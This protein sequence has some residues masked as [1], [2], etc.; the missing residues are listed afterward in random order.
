MRFFALTIALWIGVA[1]P[2]PV[3]AADEKVVTLAAD[4][5]CPYNCAP[6]SDKPGILVEIAKQAF[7]A[8]GYKLDYRN[9]VWTRAIEEARTGKIT[10]IIGA[11]KGDAPDFIFPET[12]QA[13]SI[14]AFYAP[15]TS[16][17]RYTGLDSLEDISLGVI[18]GYAYGDDIDAYIA[19][20]SDNLQKIQSLDGDEALDMNILKLQKGRIHALVESRNVMQFQLAEKNLDQAIIEVGALPL[21]EAQNLYIAFSPADEQSHEYAK[22]LADTTTAMEK[23]GRLDALFKKYGISSPAP[24]A[25]P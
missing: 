19:K 2:V 11:A 5:W 23:D 21:T 3:K 15:A 7:E 20:N 18:S 24:E 25:T 13:A 6:D 22:I 17:W 8:K 10:G 4:I 14:M 16:T 9:I 1:L 12:P